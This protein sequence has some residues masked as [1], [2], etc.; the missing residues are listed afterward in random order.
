MKSIDLISNKGNLLKGPLILVPEIYEDERGF[1]YESWN[2]NQFNNIIGKNTYFVQDNH[3]LSHLGV[4]R[5]LHYQVDPKPQEKLVRCIGGSIFDI[6]LDIRK[7]SPTFGEWGGIEIDNKKKI[8]FWIPEGFAHGFIALENNSE[9]VY[10]TT[11]YWSKLYDR[12]IRW[13]D[14]SLNI[15]WPIN[16]KIKIKPVLSLKD[17]NA[18][19][20]KDADIFYNK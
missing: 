17:K 7:N 8:Q 14:P 11:E 1:F 19:L 16:K 13:N 2:Q 9:V 18:P 12:S 6:A 4:V 15:N 3:S 10:K 5:G 20:L